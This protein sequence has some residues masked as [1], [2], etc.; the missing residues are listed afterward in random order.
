MR[1]KRWIIISAAVLAGVIALALLI[2]F[3]IDLGRF[4]DN[5]ERYASRATGREF[6][7]DGEFQATLGRSIL[8]KAQ[9]V[10]LANAEWGSNPDMLQIGNLELRVNLW[11]LL[12]GPVWIQY[13]KLDR[14]RIVVEANP[15]KE[16]NWSFDPATK[17]TQWLE[18]RGVTQYVIERADIEDFDLRYGDGWL[19]TARTLAIDRGMA[20]ETADDVVELNLSGHLDELRLE[21]TGRAG[22]LDHLLDGEDVELDISGSLGEF[23]VDARG[24]VGRMSPLQHPE[25]T[26]ELSAPEIRSVLTDVGLPAITSGPVDLRGNLDQLDPG[27][28]LDVTGSVGGFNIDLHATLDDAERFEGLVTRFDASG[29][30]LYQLARVL[31]LDFMPEGE[32]TLSGQIDGDQ[33]PFRLHDVSLAIGDVSAA[34]DGT[35]GKEEVD[36]LVR[37]EGPDLD[38]FLD[39]WTERNLPEEAFEVTGRAYRRYD[40]RVWRVSDVVT[41]LQ[42]G[43]EL[44]IDGSLDPAT[45]FLGVDAKVGASGPE[46]SDAFAH[47]LT[48]PLALGP[49]E[50]TARLRKS[51]TDIRFEELKARFGDA[52]RDADAM[53]GVSH[54]AGSI[55]YR[56][57][58]LPLVTAELTSEGI[59]LTPYFES[60][61]ETDAEPDDQQSASDRFIP[62]MRLPRRYLDGAT[63]DIRLVADEIKLDRFSATNVDVNLRLQDGRL[64]LDPVSGDFRNGTVSA[65]LTLDSNVEMPALT[66][67]LKARDIKWDQLLTDDEGNSLQTPTLHGSAQLTATGTGLRQLLASSNG[68][69]RIEETA[70]FMQHD[71][72]KDLLG[73]I[74]PPSA[75]E[76]YIR[77]DCYVAEFDI[78]DGI[79]SASALAIQTDKLRI[80][81]R[82]RL[83]FD[84]EKID[85]RFKIAKREGTGVSAVSL[86]SPLVSINGTLQEPGVNFVTGA[87][88]AAVVTEGWT[89][90]IDAFADLTKAGDN[91]CE[92][93]LRRAG[94]RRQLE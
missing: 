14:T 76:K 74:N 39:Y 71:P 87:G 25:V 75:E 18:S 34:I 30:N 1:A 57:A 9:D 53:H 92:E 49:F 17:A 56:P 94:G 58:D 66:A 36:L 38:A 15:G 24:S 79:A 2:L 10:R 32:F 78:D 8:V 77:L 44:Y 26:F 21:V 11:S 48:K 29:P 35:I 37:G 85:L 23:R 43:L 52:L 80:G 90:L 33:L 4:K 84:T 42:S 81:A 3:T 47:L 12:S 67:E 69:I 73:V 68:S 45:T 22:P 62:D 6:T 16:L 50:A 89:I 86:L 31:E 55:L 83:D 91:I 65:R 13:V 70:G 46:F 54:L 20:E 82:G 63:L 51:E 88:V 28:K 27:L 40:S 59:D 72:L 61:D 7:I 93:S 19:D 64:S 60:E 41:K 5:F